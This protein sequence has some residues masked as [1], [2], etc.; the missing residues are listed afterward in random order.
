MGETFA[1]LKHVDD[2][3]VHEKAKT[4]PALA[5]A[6]KMLRPGNW[7]TSGLTP[8]EAL[9]IA[10]ENGIPVCFVPPPHVLKD[11]AAADPDDRVGVLRAN[12]A[13]VLDQCARLIESFSAPE[14]EDAQTLTRSALDAYNNGNHEAA[15]ALA[16]DVAEPLAFKATTQELHIF[17]SAAD[18]IAYQKQVRSKYK[19]AAHLL[20]YIATH[21]DFR[22]WLVYWRAL[23]SPLP[24][25][26]TP[27]D[28]EAGD[29]VPETASRH[30]TV[31]NPTVEHLS[32]ENALIALML[33]TSLLSD[34]QS[35]YEY[36]QDRRLAWEESAQ[37]ERRY[38]EEQAR[39][40][41]SLG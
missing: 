1:Q 36:E 40:H 21:K 30:A 23:L 38:W 26:F 13:A 11:L 25:F 32:E 5:A 34:R 24:R 33:C 3:D 29:Q 35:W 18:Q 8:D 41:E 19:Q 28:R 15:M 39:E 22:S 17:E 14:I 9:S 6:Y 37:D 20:K 10:V 27:Y 7:L 31:H 2:A 12:E 16:V 4:N